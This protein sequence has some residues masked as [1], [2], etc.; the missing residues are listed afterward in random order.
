MHPRREFKDP[1]FDENKLLEK[2]ELSYEARF[3]KEDAPD[4]HFRK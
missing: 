4:K 3:S 1:N 2:Y